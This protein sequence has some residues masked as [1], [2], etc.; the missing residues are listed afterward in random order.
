MFPARNNE[1]APYSNV[2]NS[3][4]AMYFSAYANIPIV[5]KPTATK[6]KYNF[7]SMLIRS[8][9]F[10]RSLSQP[11]F[12]AGNRIRSEGKSDQRSRRNRGQ[13]QVPDEVLPRHP[14]RPSFD[15]CS[16]YLL[17]S[18]NHALYFGIV[19]IFL[20]CRSMNRPR[21]AAIPTFGE[22]GVIGTSPLTPYRNS[23]RTSASMFFPSN[24]PFNRCASAGRHALLRREGIPPINRP[25]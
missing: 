2:L 24:K 17:H 11:P 6:V 20:Q 25:R 8:L 9:G 14:V 15:G 21:L 3:P 5:A 16:D 13:D 19:V 4:A 22:S 1:S 23:P 10:I 18:C 7:F 12:P